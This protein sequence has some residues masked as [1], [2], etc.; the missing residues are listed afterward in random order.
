MKRALAAAAFATLLAAALVPDVTSLRA[1]DHSAV[2][3]SLRARNVMTGAGR[4]PG[5]V[6]DPFGLQDL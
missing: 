4:A 3:P 2:T 5:D 1:S 6:L